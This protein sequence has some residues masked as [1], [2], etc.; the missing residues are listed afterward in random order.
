VTVGGVAQEDARKLARLFAKPAEKEQSLGLG[1]PPFREED[2]ATGLSFVR[3]DLNAKG[4]WT[5]EADVRR[6]TLDTASGTVILD[7]EVTPGPRHTIG[8]PQV[9]S[10]DGRGVKL[11]TA[12]VQPFAGRVAN[13]GNLNAMRLA[14]EETAIGRGYPDASLRMGR[15]LQGGVFTP[16]FTIDLGKRVRL[17]KVSITGLQRT[18]PERILQRVKA[19][20]GG[21]YD[22][23]LMNRR[24]REFLATGAFQSA[25]VE[26]AGTGGR[27]VDATLH[28]EEARAK[29]VSLAAGFGSYQGF[30]T[31]ATY[32]DRNLA[33]TLRGLGAGFELGSR[34]LLGE[35]RLSDP[36]PGGKDLPALL[37]AYALIY[38]REGY[39]AYETGIE[40]RVGW[41]PGGHY[42][43]ELLAG[44]SLVNLTDDGLPVSELGE[45]VYTHPRLRLTQTLEFRDNPVLPKHGW[46]LQCPLE[47]GAAVGDVS[48]SYLMA[49]LSGGWIRELNPHYDI[50]IGGALKVLVPSGEGADLPIDLR[51][52]NG[53][54]RSVRSFPERELGPTVDGYATGGEAMWNLNAELV[55]KLGA[56]LKAVAF[57]DAGSLAR[58]YRECASADIEVAGGLGIRLD[59]PIGPVRLEYGRNLTRDPGEPPG[60]FHFA[61]GAAF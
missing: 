22:Q 40:G 43:L 25:R 57:L 51:L 3:Q 28:F 18:R 33:G 49:G 14:A 50:G 32:A 41:K 44:W 12:A 1:A 46:H 45:N 7:I 52:F 29:E 17:G 6:R 2:V 42:S 34:S 10:M 61:I 47:I 36:W 55:R 16:V 60:T 11:V 39:D 59:L 24:L 20:E 13:T 53:G 15:T 54:A 5:A 58:D 37:R 56:S 35:V 19:M 48:T 21:W 8:M 31:R 26:T 23:S 30:I 9:S 4:Y 38:S 27:V